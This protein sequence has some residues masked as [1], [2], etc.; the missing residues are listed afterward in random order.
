LIDRPR[1]ANASPN[2]FRFVRIA[3]RVSSSN[4]FTNSSNST[5]AGVAA[6]SGIVSPSANVSLDLPRVS[7]TYLS[8]SADF[9]RTSTVESLASGDASRSSFI[10][11]TATLVPSRRRWATISSTVPTRAPPIRTSPPRTSAAALGSSALSE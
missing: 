3:S 10:E 1:P 11:I 2:P 9:E 4:M 5:G 7:S 6:L 8:P